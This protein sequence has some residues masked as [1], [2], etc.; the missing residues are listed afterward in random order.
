MVERNLKCMKGLVRQL[1]CI[2]GS[3]MEEYMVY[4]NML[5]VS[6]HLPKLASKLNLRPICDSNSNKNFEGEYLKGKCR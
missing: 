3:M 6:E 2:E 5:Y 1:P 4:H